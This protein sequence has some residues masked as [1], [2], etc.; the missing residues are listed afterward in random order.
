MEIRFHPIFEPSVIGV[1]LS[2]CIN[3][4]Y[5]ELVMSCIFVGA[6]NYANCILRAVTD[7]H[8]SIHFNKH[9]A[10]SFL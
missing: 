7:S 6:C 2:E 9:H 1:L 4:S 8:K 5:L 10:I 3:D